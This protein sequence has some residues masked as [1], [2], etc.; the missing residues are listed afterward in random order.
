MRRAHFEAQAR[1]GLE[2]VLTPRGFILAAQGDIEEAEP[3][4]VF[5]ADPEDFA[6]RYPGLWHFYADLAESCIDLWV[7]FNAM[8]GRIR[9]ELEGDD[10]VSRA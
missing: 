9:C 6:R 5:E 4:A 2:D 1:R 10:L 3:S 8:N 7:H